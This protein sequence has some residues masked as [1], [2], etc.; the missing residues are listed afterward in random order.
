MPILMIP[1]ID[2]LVVEQI[3]KDISGNGYDPN[4]LGKS[5]LLKE[6]VLPVPK[7][8]RMVVLDVSPA[9]HG[10]AVGIGIF[11]V[12]TRKLF[13][14][15]NM[16]AMYANDIALG[17]LDDCK[18]P[19]VAADEEEAIRVA[20]KVLRENDP[21]E[22]EDRPHPGHPPHG[23]DPGVGG[24]AGCGKGRPPTGAVRPRINHVSSSFLK[25]RSGFQQARS[26]PRSNARAASTFLCK[27]Q[28][29]ASLVTPGVPVSSSP[30]RRWQVKRS[31]CWSW[32][33][34]WQQGQSLTQALVVKGGQGV[35]QDDGGLFRQTQAAHRQAQGQVQLVRRAPGQGQGAA[36]G[37]VVRRGGGAL[38][39]PS[40]GHPAVALPGE[41]GE[42]LPGQPVQGGGKP[43]L[44]PGVGCSSADRARVRAWC[45][46]RRCSS[47]C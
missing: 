27:V 26:R 11:D 6:F 17:C 25:Q 45:S 28:G 13:D 24:P 19:L 47:C 8:G 31:T 30:S 37:Q 35:V 38:Q 15:L 36:G 9:S 22:A 2:V 3:G 33:S 21:E 34:S 23:G 29:S 43:L 46:C 39:L 1:D 14:Q 18:I 5:F 4:I 41:P 40:E 7:I 16:E 42:I 44:Q 32:A 10:S 12:T 20:V